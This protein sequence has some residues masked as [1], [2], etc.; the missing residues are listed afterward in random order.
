MG[1]TVTFKIYRNVPDAELAQQFLTDHDIPSRV[2]V[3]EISGG[4][5]LLLDENDLEKAQ[6]LLLQ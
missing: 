1:R 3:D 4:V 5:K 6:E 2:E